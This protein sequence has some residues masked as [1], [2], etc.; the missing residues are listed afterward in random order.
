[1]VDLKLLELV[2]VLEQV[3][4]G[5][6]RRRIGLRRIRHRGSYNRKKLT[7]AGRNGSPG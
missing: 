2:V 5:R 1:L 7:P 4:L 6:L 3:H